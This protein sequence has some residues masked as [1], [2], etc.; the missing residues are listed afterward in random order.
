MSWNLLIYRPGAN[1]Q[2][3]EPLGPLDEVRAKLNTTFP[4]LVWDSSTEC[5]MKVEGGF[6]AE[7]T[8]ENEL[9]SDIYTRG[10]YNHLKPLAGLCL[11]EGWRLGDAQEGED[12]DLDDPYRWYEEHGG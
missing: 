5:G 4:E 7:L 10:G 6:L 8:L 9:V 2:T 1:N 11:R 12:V 3:T